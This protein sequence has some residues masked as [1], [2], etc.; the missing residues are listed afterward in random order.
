MKILVIG[1]TGTIGSKVAAAL[2][3][4]HEVL[5][6][7][8]NG[9]VQVDIDQPQ[10]IQRMFQKLGK[11]D[12]IV[13]A[14]GNAKFG[15]LGELGDADYEFS[16]KSKLMGQVNL[17]RRGLAH[18]TP[19]GSI[20]LTSGVLSTQPMVGSAAISLV[21]AGVEAFV[22]AAALEFPAGQRVNV[23]SPGWVSETLEKM[24]RDPAQGIAA[25]RVAEVYVRAVKG[26]DHGAVLG[27]F[28]G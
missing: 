20:T 26:T 25:A 3:A 13:S 14:A 9:D 4:K 28:E 19:N 16:L 17:V 23:V 10:S 27:A 22:R 2:E 12:A 21:N 8:R 7:S 5:R 24:G 15:K 18:L 11:V 6:A 1:A